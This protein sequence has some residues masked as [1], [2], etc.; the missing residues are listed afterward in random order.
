VW[1][2]LPESAEDFESL[3]VEIALDRDMPSAKY[4]LYVSPITASF[5]N[6]ERFYGGLQ[7]NIGGA[8]AA[9]PS[10]R[11]VSGDKGKGAIFSRWGEGLDLTFV[12]PEPDGYVEAADY[13]GSFVSGRRPYHWKAGSYIFEIRR[14][15]PDPAEEGGA[16][17]LGAYVTD[18]ASGVSTHI[19][20]LKFKG[21][22]LRLDSAF[23]GF[24]EF[25]GGKDVDIAKLPPLEIRFGP[26]AFN[27]KRVAAVRVRVIHPREEESSAAPAIMS[28]ALSADKE[29]VVCRLKDKVRSDQPDDYLLLPLP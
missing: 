28:V 15:P 11:P 19:S 13:E 22:K 5:Q 12:R 7:T 21:G 6:G 29:T 9:N 4:N 2:T 23:A 25:Y 20:S 18:K 27:G 24:V 3:S 1:W 16:N 26:V 14:M 17:W 10:Q 8:P